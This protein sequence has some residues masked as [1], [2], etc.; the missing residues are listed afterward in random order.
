MSAAFRR[1]VQLLLVTLVINAGG[2]T[3]SREAVADAFLG[4]TTQTD[5]AATAAQPG[6][7]K[8]DIK[9]VVCSHW[10]HAVDHFAG[11]FYLLPP[12]LMEASNAYFICKRLIAPPALPEG[13]YRPPRLFS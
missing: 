9:G 11:I 6:E 5:D 7:G 3:F 2:W 1:I 10:C 12:L 13:L 4:Q 8:P